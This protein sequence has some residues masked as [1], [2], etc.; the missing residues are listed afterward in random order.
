MA[1]NY[2]DG[3]VWYSLTV[4]PSGLI[5]IEIQESGVC[6]TALGLYT[7]PDCST[8]PYSWLTGTDIG[9]CSN[10]GLTGPN[11]SPG[12][13][14]DPRTYGLTTGQTVYIRVWERNNNENGAFTI[15]A[16]NPAIPA[17]DEP[18]IAIPIIP[19]DPCVPAEYSTLNMQPPPA[20]LTIGIMSCGMPGAPYATPML[21]NPVVRDMWFRVVVP[22]TTNNMTVTLFSGTLDDMAMAWYRASGSICGPGY[23]GSLTQIAGASGCNQTIG[24]GNNMARI[25]SSTAGSGLVGG[26]TIYIRV[27]NQKPNEY[28]YSGTFSICVT[29][30]NPP[31]NDNPCGAIALE[32]G[33]GE[34][35]LLPTTNENATNT[36]ATF[37]P[38]A[39]TAPAICSGPANY[40]D[41]WYTVEVPATVSGTNPLII[42]TDDVQ[43]LDFTMAAYRDISGVGCPSLIQLAAVGS[44]ATGGSLQGNGSMPR[45]VFTP[46][47]VTPGETLYIRVWTNVNN[48]QGPFSICAHTQNPPACQGTFYDSGGATGPYANPETQTRTHIPEKQGDVVILTFHQFNIENGFDFLRIYNGT[49]IPANLIGTYTG[50]SIPNQISSTV[51]AGNPTGMLTVVFNAD[52]LVNGPGYAYKVSCGAPVI[53][54]PGTCSVTAYSPGAIPNVTNSYDP[55]GPGGTTYPGNLGV[56]SVS[57]PPYHVRYCPSTA[58]D[59]VTL[60]FTSFD[61]EDN[62]DGLYVFNADIAP[63][64]ALNTGVPLATQINS[65]NGAQ[66]T[67]SGAYFPP[68]PPTGAFWGESS[69][70]TITA[71]IGPNNPNGCLTLVFYTDAIVSGSGW[72]ADVR[73]GPPPP[74]PPPT[75]CDALFYETP[76]GSAG[77]YGNNVSSTQTFASQPGRIL[78]ATFQMFNVEPVW[79]KM[80]AFNGPTTASP[81]FASGN[82]IGLGPAPFGAGAYWGTGIP[83]PFT[84]SGP[85]SPLTFHFVTDNSVVR[86]GW[87]ARLSCP[88]QVANDEPCVLAPSVTGATLITP[89]TS[90]VL[91]P[92]TTVNSTRTTSVAAPSCGNYQGGDVWFR[93]VAPPSGRV[94]IDTRAGTLTDAAM[95]LYSS[96]TCSGP[97][98]A[99]ECDDDDGP[100]LMPAIDRMCNTLTPGATYWVRVWGYGNRTGTFDLCIVEGPMNTTLQSDCGGAFSLCNSTTFNGIAYGNGCGPDLSGISMGCLA[101]GE[102]QGSWYSFRTNG[103]G[104]LS[105]TITP[106]T[107]SD[108]DWAIW[109]GVNLG[110]PTPVGASC[111]ALGAPIRC[112]FASLTNTMTVGGANPTAATGMGRNT[113]LPVSGTAFAAPTPAVIDAA[114]DGW[115]PGIQVGA[116][117]LYLLFVDDHHLNGNSYTVTWT[118][119]A[120]VMGCV[121][122]PVEALQLEA[123]PQV[124]SV[125]LTWTT[126]M[127]E[128][129]SHY[130][131][132]RSKD[133]QDFVPIGRMEAVGQSTTTTEY[134]S[135]DFAP[136]NGL[137]YYRLQQVDNDGTTALSNVVTALFEP[138]HATVMVVP[139]PARDQ[140]ELLLSTA[141][142]GDLLVRITD[143]SGRLVASFL[144]PSGVQRMELPIAKLE[145]G[146][147]TVQLLTEKGEPHARTRFVKQ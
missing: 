55:G 135:T 51:S 29:P 121:I 25:N 2:S 95:A 137:N 54:A 28:F 32:V 30:N 62:F 130:I 129:N 18:C 146:S 8:G 47:T 134:R 15:C 87:I 105:M 133:G 5:G 14:F 72:E 80:Y 56:Q 109:Q 98:T 69:P 123:K 70:G 6:A 92:G 20:G 78:T 144:T 102:R 44:C 71:T 9:L 143:G 76:G 82:G 53:V 83:G 42:D 117:Q 66:L 27:W 112:T 127:E 39:S 132:E 48:Q 107:P 17:G 64:T 84:A 81:M 21:W 97:F 116:N 68:V 1:V 22:V 114:T 145:G 40:L 26:E 50:T 60:N 58:G 93:F 59:P 89:S 12:I 119:S 111:A 86:P 110:T 19:G 103:T 75:P 94:F 38:G 126:T 147:Y 67:W 79:D 74:P 138:K 120:A 115:L 11:N 52:N 99:I 139:N 125:D 100:G 108:V 10:D 140:A 23:G 104:D 4:P 33:A 88:A 85:N 49:A 122:L 131:I 7:A 3:D 34:C 101:G 41:V 77:N 124:S 118:E 36:G 73:C 96:V 43:P 63:G 31:P 61:V 16:Y 90:C 136:Q 91:I 106:S 13:V 128:N 37:L 65:G 57:V 45:L 113:F 142:E 141:Y 46:P 35:T 24:A